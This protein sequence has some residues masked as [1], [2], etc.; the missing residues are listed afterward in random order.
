MP[1][2]N[3]MERLQK[4]IAR[5]GIASRRRAELLIAGGHVELNGRLVTEAGTKADP[6]KDHI[7]VDGKKIRPDIRRVVL[8][9]NK[10]RGYMTTCSDPEGRPTVMDLVEA[11]KERVTPVGRLDYDT[12]GLLLLTN[13]GDLANAL[14]HPKQEVEK[15]YW[16]KVRGHVPPETLQ[17][18]ARG[19]ISLPTGKTLPCRI[20]LLNTTDQ[21]AWVEIVL[22]EGKKR[23]VRRMLQRVGHPVVKLK[24]VAYAFLKLG[25][26]ALGKSRYLTSYEVE[27][28]EYLVGIR[29]EA[30]PLPKKARRAQSRQ[31]RPEKKGHP[32]PRHRQDIK[33]QRRK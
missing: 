4:I 18:I 27:K 10:P 24:R 33:Q 15:L 8:M 32:L 22:H 29:S 5:A 31:V 2:A 11:V 14:M 28:L 19:G 26:L 7:K 6:A 21:N 23:E 20:R 30:P 1:D 13:D 17:K 25:K 9:L 3:V 16:A 12:E